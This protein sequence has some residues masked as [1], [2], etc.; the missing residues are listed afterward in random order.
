MMVIKFIKNFIFVAVDGKMS[1]PFLTFFILIVQKITLSSVCKN[2]F[3]FFNTFIESSLKKIPSVTVT[4]VDA[5]LRDFQLLHQRV[6][7]MH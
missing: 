3:S 1:D 5:R 6:L 4:Q 7:S 2:H